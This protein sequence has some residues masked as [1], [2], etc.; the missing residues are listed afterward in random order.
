MAL[1]GAAFVFLSTGAFVRGVIALR[2]KTLDEHTRFLLA[3]NIGIVLSTPL[4]PPWT[5]PILQTASPTMPLIVTFGAVMF[6]GKRSSQ[7][8]ELPAGFEWTTPRLLGAVA[9]GV[10]LL[11]LFPKATPERSSRPE[12]T[13]PDAAYL[14]VLAGTKVALVNARDEPP[15]SLPRLHADDLAVSLAFLRRHNLELV[16]AIESMDRPGTVLAYAYDVCSQSAKLV[17]D[18][19]GALSASAGYTSF[20]VVKTRSPEVLHVVASAVEPK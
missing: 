4:L 12:C 14:D 10:A 16:S 9:L 13:A 8:R 20:H 6:V 11:L 15:T 7:T 3:A 5:T 17:L 19:T 18:D 1:F 2:Q